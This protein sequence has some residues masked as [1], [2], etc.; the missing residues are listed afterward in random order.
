M[1]IMTNSVR[2]GFAKV[3]AQHG[4]I[5]ILVN[6]AGVPGFPGGVEEAP[7][8]AF[9]QVMETNFGHSFKGPSPL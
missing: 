2:E 3:T 4:P 5:D 9:R 7:V 6:N 1:S 8:D